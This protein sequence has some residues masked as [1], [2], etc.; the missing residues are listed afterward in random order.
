MVR[1][2]VLSAL[3]VCAI[4]AFSPA[5]QTC[6]KACCPSHFAVANGFL[7][8]LV[9]VQQESKKESVSQFSANYDRQK[10][11]SFLVLTANAL[12][13]IAAHFGELKDSA[14]EAAATSLSTRLQLAAKQIEGADTDAAAKKDFEALNL[15]LHLPKETVTAVR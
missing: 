12:H 2:F 9:A 10:A 5:Q 8:Q 7:D 14:N 15:D 6:T 3:A 13:D 1:R 4:A 11:K